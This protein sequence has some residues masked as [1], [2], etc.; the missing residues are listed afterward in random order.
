[1]GGVTCGLSGGV[2]IGA[3]HECLC[4]RLPDHGD[5]VHTCGCGAAW[6]FCHDCGRPASGAVCL[7]CG[8]DWP[9][10]GEPA[11]AFAALTS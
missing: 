10:N 11:S 9:A 5:G 7:T 4:N 8:Y 2:T 6:R 3:R 1:M